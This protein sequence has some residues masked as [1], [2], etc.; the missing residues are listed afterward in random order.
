MESSIQLSDFREAADYIAGFPPLTQTAAHIAKFPPFNEKINPEIFLSKEIVELTQTSWYWVAK[1]LEAFF[2]DKTDPLSTSEATEEITQK[3]N[4]IFVNLAPELIQTKIEALRFKSS[5]YRIWANLIFEGETFIRAKAKELEFPIPE[6]RS[7]ILKLIAF[8][9]CLLSIMEWL[10]DWEALSKAQIN[11]RLRD[12]Q[13]YQQEKIDKAIILQRSKRWD[14][15]E[16]KLLN[17]L[18]AY[19]HICP[20]TFFCLWVFEGHKKNLPSH[21]AFIALQKPPSGDDF[22]GQYVKFGIFA[23]EY[24]EHSRG[25]KGKGKPKKS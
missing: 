6:R 20:V 15:E 7:D 1:S 13:H 23:G 22:R 24:K 17:T 10:Y 21:A 11:E 4:K 19:E 9:E 8:E 16:G 3:L 25:T 2:D 5:Q 14:K 18:P 12:W